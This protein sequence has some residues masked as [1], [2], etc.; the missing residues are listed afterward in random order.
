[1]LNECQKKKVPGRRFG[2]RH[3]AKE[4]TEQ[5]SG[6]FRHKNTPAVRYATLLLLI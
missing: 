2:L 1:V 3:S 6:A 5:R 4:L